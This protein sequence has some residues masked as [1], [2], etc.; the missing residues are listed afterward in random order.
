MKSWSGRTGLDL[1]SI[2]RHGAVFRFVVRKA[3]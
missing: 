3:R 2:E 1:M